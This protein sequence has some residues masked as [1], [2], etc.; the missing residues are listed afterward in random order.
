MAR[1]VRRQLWIGVLFAVWASVSGC[2][3]V[4]GAN[5]PWALWS[6]AGRDDA[7]WEE[8]MRSADR[9]REMGDIERAQVG[10]LRAWQRAPEHPLARVRIAQL[11]LLRD[12]ALAAAEFRSVLAASPEEVRAWTGLGVAA[13]ALG[14]LDEAREAFAE[15]TRRAPDSALAHAG[16]AVTLDLLGRP[17][18]AREQLAK[19]SHAHPE[20]AWL[21]NNLGVSRLLAKDWSGAEAALRA[22]LELEPG[23]ASAHNNLGLALGGQERYPEA[24][25]AFLEAGGERAARN[26]L[27]YVYFLNRRHAEAVGQY[28]LALAA[29][30]GDARVVLDNLNAA[31]D[32]M[33]KKPVAARTG[34]KLR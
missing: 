29:E 6:G 13:L 31:L 2:A 33:E 8:L 11:L 12:P 24:F 10:Y 5:A 20:D 28:E 25:A 4:F 15:A 1:Q 3:H 19:A 30:G 34:P 16:Q 26:N 17:E 7:T 23:D 21:L 32:A 22:A 14:R 27:G 9:F 18:E